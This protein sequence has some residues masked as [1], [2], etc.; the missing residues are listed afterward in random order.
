MISYLSLF[1]RNSLTGTT[2]IYHYCFDSFFNIG[3]HL[4]NNSNISHFIL[5]QYSLGHPNIARN[6]STKD[7][8]S[9]EE[10]SGSTNGTEEP[11]KNAESEN[12]AESVHGVSIQKKSS[13]ERS[14]V[15]TN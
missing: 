6:D 15:P 1:N 14:T 7:G 9:K 4:F 13:E 12:S 8:H 11:T 5:G 10:H 2:Q 3:H